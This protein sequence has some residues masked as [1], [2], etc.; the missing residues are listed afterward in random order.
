MTWMRMSHCMFRPIPTSHEDVMPHNSDD[1]D[2]D[3]KAVAN[4]VDTL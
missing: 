2:D 1:M 3:V 4:A